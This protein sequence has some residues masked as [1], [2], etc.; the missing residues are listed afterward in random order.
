MVAIFQTRAGSRSYDDSRIMG[1]N[2]RQ[3][4]LLRQRA[5]GR[6]CTASRLFQDKQERGGERAEVKIKA[7]AAEKKLT[8]GGIW[9][10]RSSTPR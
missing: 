5:I 2:S 7:E 6:H 3:S 4:I 9:L 10:D 8:H 1:L